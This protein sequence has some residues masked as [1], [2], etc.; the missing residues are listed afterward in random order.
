[1]DEN[2]ASYEPSSFT[3]DLNNLEL[4]KDD[5]FVIPED[6]GA[7]VHEWWHYFQDISTITGQ[8]GFYMMMRDLARVSQTTCSCTGNIISLPLDKDTFGDPISKDRKL[9]NVI[10]GETINKRILDFSISSSPEI[11]TTKLKYEG[12]SK[13]IAKCNLKINNKD[14]TLGIIALQ[15]INCFYVQK[16]AEK[17]SPKPPRVSADSLP[18]FPYKVGELLFTYYSIDADL[19]SKLLITYLCLDSIQAPVVLLKMLEA[20]KENNY[21]FKKDRDNIIKI[22]NEVSSAYSE[23]NDQ[24]Y[25]EWV[26]DYDSWIKDETKKHL[27]DSLKWY[28]NKL[29]G[30]DTIKDR[31]G[32]GCFIADFCHS[33]RGF[34]MLYSFFPVPIFKKDGMLYGSSM[35]GKKPIL[36]FQDEYDNAL[37]LWFLKRVY[38]LLSIKKSSDLQNY[39]ECELY[40]KCQYRDIVDKDYDCK[41]AA[42]EVIQ[43]EKKAKCPYGLALHTMGLWQN[44]IEIKD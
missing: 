19:A 3:V 42:W 38:K 14:Y 44:R 29:V 9:Y 31:M 23:G 26:K 28:L 22:F 11:E 2:L 18:E 27:S 21:E 32:Q 15:E 43:D 10:C 33:L 35:I 40:S 7:F 6:F 36:N 8:F 24:I 41:T 37:F 34:Q 39:A 25:S 17:Y 30:I 4:S 1:M 5:D 13:D 20:L 16:I 12:H